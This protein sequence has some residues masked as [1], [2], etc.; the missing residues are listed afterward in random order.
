MMCNHF[1]RVGG[2]NLSPLETSAGVVSSFGAVVIAEIPDSL[3]EYAPNE[4]RSLEAAYIHPGLG[5]GAAV[6]GLLRVEGRMTLR[7]FYARNI[8]EVSPLM[9]KEELCSSLLI[10]L[11]AGDS[12][13]VPRVV[14]CRSRRLPVGEDIVGEDLVADDA[15][16]LFGDAGGVAEQAGADSPGYVPTTPPKSPDPNLF[17][18]DGSEPGEEGLPSRSSGV[19]RTLG[20]DSG[21]EGEEKRRRAYYIF[22]RG[23]PACESGMNAPGIRHNKACK[24]RN[25]STSVEPEPAVFHQPKVPEH[26]ED[27]KRA[28]QGTKRSSET[29]LERLEEEIKSEEPVPLTI[30]SIGLSWV[31]TCEP[32]HG[33]VFDDVSSLVTPATSEDVFDERVTSIKFDASQTAT[34]EEVKLCGTSV[35]LWRPT[36]A[37]DDTTLT[38]LDTD[39]T[40][41]GMKEE[42]ANMSKCEVGVVLDG[43]EIEKI[44]ASGDGVRI[45][46][47]RWVTAYKNEAR[48]RARIV[49]KDVP[50]R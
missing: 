31:D 16:D 1:G 40:Y 17:G 41:L 46:Q 25:A 18:D 48:V 9:W 49:A 38:K 37:V 24:L 34:S 6:E 45:I 43:G 42:L 44:K 10:P 21:G 4:T 23:C 11:D 28:Y 39:L 33:L 5:T 13:V 26:G 12:Q 50:D 15:V 3:R 27:Q 14:D 47:A 7:R 36:E 29:S 19:K 30:D 22:T 2:A 8:R 35:L 32:L 20:E